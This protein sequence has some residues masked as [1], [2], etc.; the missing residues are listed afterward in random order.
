VAFNGS[1]AWREIL[2]RIMDGFAAEEGVSPDWLVNPGTRR[3]LKLDYYYP[4]AL[5]AIRF[6]GATGNRK[7][8]VSEQERQEA[9]GRDK[10]REE[11]CEA[12]G[13][14]LVG[15]DLNQGEPQAVL[16]EISASLSRSI[17]RVT[18]G[19]AKRQAA[20][21]AQR[22]TEARSRSDSLGFRVRSHG[23][24]AVFAD[25]YRDRLYAAQSPQP[26]PA[27]TNGPALK[28]PEGARVHHER[29]G[30][31]VVTAVDKDEHDSFVSVRFDDGSERRFASSLLAGRMKR[32][33]SGRTKDK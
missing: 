22:L 4:E 8:P 25:L 23:D 26:A 17:R 3:R 33:G 27:D 2:M 19:G 9:K 24:L 12:Q 31:G 18:E 32:L 28:L 30:T 5:L 20:A 7:A 21:L 29:F 1:L 10:T 6:E 16:R 15:I 14:S 13:V 11:L